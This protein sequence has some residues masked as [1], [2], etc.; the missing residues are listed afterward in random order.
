MVARCENV[1]SRIANRPQVGPYVGLR[2]WI[3]PGPSVLDKIITLE[4]GTEMPTS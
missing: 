2:W 3:P 4:L 1:P